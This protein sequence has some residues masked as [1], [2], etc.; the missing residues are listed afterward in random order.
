MAGVGK[1]EA[2]SPF[3]S[4][5]PRLGTP[6]RQEAEH[7][8]SKKHTPAAELRARHRT[9]AQRAIS[10]LASRIDSSELR[11]QVHSLQ[12]S[13]LW[14]EQALTKAVDAL[15]AT[16]DR[17]GAV[18]PL[19]RS[20]VVERPQT[21][22]VVRGKDASE[23]GGQ[24]GGQTSKARRKLELGTGNAASSSRVSGTPRAK[25]SVTERPWRER[26]V[27]EVKQRH[28]V[29]DENAFL[30]MRVELLEKE[31]LSYRDRVE[32]LLKVK[33]ALTRCVRSVTNPGK[34]Y[35]PG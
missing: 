13:L 22:H 31:S 28:A 32:V 29:E 8:P 33:D 18:T 3:V 16:S 35:K 9:K 30:R 10:V 27:R 11:E 2:A 20:P 14:Y 19:L 21:A 26:Y 5:L 12:V 7:S 6:D 1:G 15:S 17:S 23:K 24:S 34:G 4:S 25:E